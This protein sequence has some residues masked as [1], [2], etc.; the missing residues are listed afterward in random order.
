MVDIYW[1]A[2]LHD[3]E[4]RE[5]NTKAAS[6]FR[7]AGHNVYMPQEHGVWEQCLKNFNG[8]K[9]MTRSYFYHL[10]II[11]M[12]RSNICVVYHSRKTGP[13]EGQ[14]FEMGY[15]KAQGKVVILINEVGWDFNLMPEFGADFYCE[16]VEEAI[17]FMQ[18]E[19]F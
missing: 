4:D 1:A 17:A 19:G 9:Q 10:D 8:D 3:V 12:N 2:P 11:A 15:M 14:L 6:A 18:A 5:R 16:S 13:S 7:A